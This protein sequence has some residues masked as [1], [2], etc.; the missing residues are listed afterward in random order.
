MTQERAPRTY[1]EELL[2]IVQGVERSL[3]DETEEEEP[4]EE[5]ETDQEPEP[6]P[7][8]HTEQAPIVAGK[9]TPR[10]L[11]SH[12]DTHPIVLDLVLLK[13]YG[14]DWLEWEPE[15]VH[16]YAAQDIGQLSEL[17]FSKIMA[18]KT[19]H[20]TDSYWKQWEVF[21]WCTMALNGVFPDFQVMQVPTV[22][23]A[24][25]S[26]DIADR[27]RGD[28]GWSSEV[29]RY[30]SVV[31]RHDDIFCSIPPLDFVEIDS[32][33]VPI[34]CED[35]RKRWPDVRRAG[36]E[37]RGETI[38]DEQLRRLL[39]VHSYLEESRARLRAQLPLTEHA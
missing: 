27:I 4:T 26:A 16:H 20:V 5:L 22:A 28:V 21:V 6:S 3:H 12:P 2:R 33:G 32:D 36:K 34:D 24:A 10:N 14:A 7:L 11:L 8:M 19:L 23:Q 15:T 29:S 38:L 25:V 17:N 18:C 35:L 9:V 37:P 31:H 39:V 1:E 13:H 30:L